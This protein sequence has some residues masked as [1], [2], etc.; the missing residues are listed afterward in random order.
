MTQN[1]IHGNSLNFTKRTKRI[2]KLQESID[3]VVHLPTQRQ[4]LKVSLNNLL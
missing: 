1:I 2:Q 3:A 4:R